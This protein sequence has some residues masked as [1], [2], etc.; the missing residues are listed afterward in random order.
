MLLQTER[1][2]AATA[3][4]GG[5]KTKGQRVAPIQPPPELVGITSN[6]PAKERR[7]PDRDGGKSPAG[8]RDLSQSALKN[9]VKQTPVSV[10]PIPSFLKPVAGVSEGEDGE[11]MKAMEGYIRNLSS[12]MQ[13]RMH[14]WEAENTE[15]LQSSS[16]GFTAGVGAG[17]Y[18]NYDGSSQGI[19]LYSV[20]LI[21]RKS[22]EGMPAEQGSAPQG[23]DGNP[24]T[25]EDWSQVFGT[26]QGS[27]PFLM[28]T[29]AGTPI[30]GSIGP[31]SSQWANIGV[32]SS[33]SSA[34]ASMQRSHV[35]MAGSFTPRLLAGS[36]YQGI[37]SA[38]QR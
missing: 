33:L 6:R 12:I 26:H 35:A 36:V 22:G 5:K 14:N 9:G 19:P 8:S 28:A 38:S 21:E 25:N 37:G 16:I 30:S 23:V 29:I 10:P 2:T 17:F 31:A 32:Q 4:H 34:E 24:S 7:R 3:K 20:P 18:S 15:K 13:S 27:A 11:K 1:E